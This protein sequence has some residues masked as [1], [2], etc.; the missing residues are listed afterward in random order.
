MAII[1][2]CNNDIHVWQSGKNTLVSH[3]NTKQLYQY[4]NMDVAI[5]NLYLNGYKEEAREIN[6]RKAEL[7]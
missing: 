6:A 4:P 2:K 1:L 7:K 5:T 3:E